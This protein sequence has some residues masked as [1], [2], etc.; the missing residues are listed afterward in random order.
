VA[1]RRRNPSL[2][3]NRIG[4]QV[5]GLAVG[6][7]VYNMGKTQIAEMIGKI[8]PAGGDPKVAGL[9]QIV[10]GG[11]IVALGDYL[12]SMPNIARSPLGTVVPTA[13]L[14]MAAML[15]N[16]GV[17]LVTNMSGTRRR[18]MRGTIVRSPM[19]ASQIMSGTSRLG[20]GMHGSL[21]SYGSPQPSLQRMQGSLQAYGSPQPSLQQMQGTYAPQCI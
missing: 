21:D 13:T 6:A 19:I 12:A 10:A 1:R 15:V 14:A 5:G 8:T 4:L 18:G 11:A 17:Q 16:D 7:Y 2:N 9:I 20:P 3:W